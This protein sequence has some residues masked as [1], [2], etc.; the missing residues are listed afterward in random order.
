MLRSAHVEKKGSSKWALLK[1]VTRTNSIGTCSSELYI[2]SLLKLPPPPRAAI[3]YI[4]QIEWRTSR[5]GK[6]HQEGSPLSTHVQERYNT[7]QAGNPQRERERDEKNTFIDL[8]RLFSGFRNALQR[9][10]GKKNLYTMGS[11]GVWPVIFQGKGRAVTSLATSHPTD[12]SFM[13]RSD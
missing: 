12:C 3:C 10:V 9:C 1:H 13:L 11:V 2:F 6:H 7:P 8:C 5:I 4:I